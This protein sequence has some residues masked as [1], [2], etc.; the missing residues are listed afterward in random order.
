[1][2]REGPWLG[3]KIDRPEGKKR[4]MHQA[5]ENNK[6]RA[7][8][9][10][11][12]DCRYKCNSFENKY[13]AV[14]APVLR[15]PQPLLSSPSPLPLLRLFPVQT[16]NKRHGHGSQH[17]HTY[18]TRRH[19]VCVSVHRAGGGI[20]KERVNGRRR[21]MPFGCP[22]LRCPIAYTERERAHTTLARAFWRHFS[23]IAVCD[24]ELPSSP[25]ALLA[26]NT[27][28]HVVVTVCEI[29]TNLPASNNS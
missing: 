15:Q 29:D 24:A 19:R 16:R 28:N 26:V 14:R 22:A 13:M 7:G 4:L 20:E 10:G 11:R 21:G 2:E 27:T 18:P 25:S 8:W 23:W 12:E 17:A 9:R 1:M 5:V 6:I 3:D